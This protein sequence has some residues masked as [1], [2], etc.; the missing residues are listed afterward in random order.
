[1]SARITQDTD[2]PNRS[3]PVL[4]G[5]VEQKAGCSNDGDSI[6]DRPCQQYPVSESQS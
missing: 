2:R 5:R 4:G 3:G 6:L 1:M